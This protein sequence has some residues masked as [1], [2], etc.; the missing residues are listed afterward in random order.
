[1]VTLGVLA[2]HEGQEDMARRCFQEALDLGRT[3]QLDS[4]VRSAQDRLDALAHFT[5]GKNP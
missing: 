1:M 4:I 2:L 5:A 3:V